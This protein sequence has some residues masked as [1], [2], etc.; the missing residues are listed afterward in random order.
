MIASY[1]QI[2]SQPTGVVLVELARVLQVTTDELKGKA[3]PKT[4]QLLK[5]F[6]RIERLPPSDQWAVLKFLDVLLESDGLVGG[7]AGG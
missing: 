7:A 2:D 3:E 1:E 4:A 5:K 6:R